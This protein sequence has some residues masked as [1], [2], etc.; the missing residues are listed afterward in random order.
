[1]LFRSGA[2]DVPTRVAG[3]KLLGLIPFGFEQGGSAIRTPPEGCQG[4]KQV[5]LGPLQSAFIVGE[6]GLP[7][8][9][10]LSLVRMG[11]VFLA[12]VPAEPTTT[13]GRII[14]DAVQ[15]A[16]GPAEPAPRVIVV[17]LA[18]GF[19]QYVTT[20]HEYAGQ[21]YEG[22][23]TLYGPG[24]AEFLAARFAEMA[25]SIAATGAGSPAPSVGPI[26]AY[27]GKATRILPRPDAA[28]ALD[29]GRALLS[30]GCLAEGGLRVTWLDEPPGR[31]RPADGQVL[32]LQRS[33]NGVWAAEAWDDQSDVVVESVR[34]RRA[35]AAHGRGWEW[36]LLLSRPGLGGS[37]LRLRLL[38][39]HGQ[40]E[41]L[42]APF[43]GCGNAG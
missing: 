25:R 14:G 28:P 26:T 13:T 1:M 39:R 10:Q 36:S 37:V 33:R 12:A 21:T 32:E 23:S 15:A 42:S 20:R 30:T 9:A 5:L 11:S 27:P 41:Y 24:T 38:P 31:L 35:G 16:A 29:R 8:V 6:H 22:G 7:E 18:N 40:P 3:W 34:A 19:M 4:H 2:S 43:P 17:S